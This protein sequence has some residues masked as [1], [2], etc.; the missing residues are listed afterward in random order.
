[1]RTARLVIS[2]IG[3]LVSIGGLIFVL[4]GLGMVGPS[5]SYMFNNG[6]WINNG[7]VILAVGMIVVALGT[8]LRSPT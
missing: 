2:V 3:L 8:R 7:V 5:D 6:Q 1:M 4:Q